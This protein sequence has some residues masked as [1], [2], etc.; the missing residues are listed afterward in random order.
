MAVII[1][2]DFELDIS[3][4]P[5]PSNIDS[6]PFKD[7]FSIDHLNID[8]LVAHT[9]PT[10]QMLKLDLQSGQKTEKLYTQL[11]RANCL[12]TNQPDWATVLIEYQGAS[13]DKKSLLAYLLSYRNHQSF[14]EQCIDRIFSDITMS[15]KPDKLYIQANFMRRGGIDITPVRSSV[16]E[17][18]YI[19]G[20]DWR[21]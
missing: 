16:K 20:R 2:N 5:F 11:F 6:L 1:G 12:V 10:A 7:W 15:L 9:T 4:P 8:Q 14:H 18:N 3:Y 13:W 21:Q 17:F 19:H